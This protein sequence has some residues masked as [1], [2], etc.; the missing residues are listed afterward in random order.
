M[1]K[2]KNREIGNYHLIGKNLSKVFTLTF[3]V[4]LISC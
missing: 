4:W 1:K 3:Y 2:S